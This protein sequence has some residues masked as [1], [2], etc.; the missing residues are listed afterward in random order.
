M[1]SRT[2]EKG[3]MKMSKLDFPC[4]SFWEWDN[5]IA[6]HRVFPRSNITLA[7]YAE[8]MRKGPGTPKPKGWDVSL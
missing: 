7:D 3:K 2:T 5:W 6:H 1:E 8:Y 4:V